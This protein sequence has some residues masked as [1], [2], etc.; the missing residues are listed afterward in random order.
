[1]GIIT[2]KVKTEGMRLI[3]QEITLTDKNGKTK[4]ASEYHPE[5]VLSFKPEIDIRGMTGDDG[6]LALD[7]FLDEAIVMKAKQIRVIHGKGTGALRTVIR[8]E[9]KK[10]KRVKSMRSGEYGEGDTGVTVVE[11]K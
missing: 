2:A 9:L 10:D 11:I 5:N 1:M 8:A 3:E 4:R 6:W 7:K